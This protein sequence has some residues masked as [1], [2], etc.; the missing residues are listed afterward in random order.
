MIERLPGLLLILGSAITEG[1][2]HIAFKQAADFGSH[3]HSVLSVLR[4]ALK[5][6]KLIALGVMCFVLEG[7]CWTFALKTLDVSLAYPIGSLELVVIMLL[8]LVLLKEKVGLRRWV[9][10]ALI[11]GG[12]LLVGAS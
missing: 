5:Q 12:T 4:L 8:C 11:V 1:L 9:G 7:L 10:V 2:G 3:G 6:Y